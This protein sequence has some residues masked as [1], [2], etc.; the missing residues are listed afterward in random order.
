M[1]AL[2]LLPLPQ[3]APAAQ[4]QPN[5]WRGTLKVDGAVLVEVTGVRE[6]CREVFGIK[7]ATPAERR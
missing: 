6:L 4:G 7:P 5:L 1:T 2:T 3:D